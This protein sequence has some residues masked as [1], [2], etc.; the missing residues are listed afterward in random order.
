MSGFAEGSSHDFGKVPSPYAGRK[1]K[2]SEHLAISSLWFATNFLWGALL[3]LLIPNQIRA[4]VPQYRAEILGLMIGT[5][6]VIAI[7]VPLI[8][9][10]LSD[11]C[12]SRFGRRRPFIFSGILINIAGLGLMAAAYASTKPVPLGAAAS[13]FD[14][15]SQSPGIII[16][17]LAFL[18]VQLGNNIATAPYSGIIPDLIEPAQR[19]A[20]SGYMALMSQAGTLLGALVCG[21]LLG[22]ASDTIKYALIS[23]VLLFGMLITVWKVKENPL[24]ET[25]SKI[26]WGPYIKSLWISPK[27]H[28]NFAWVWITRALVMLGFYS[29]QPFINYYLID[30]IGVSPKE[31]DNV[32]PILLAVILFTSSISGILGGNISDRIGRKKVVYYANATIAIT[33]IGFIFCNTVP[34]VLL[35]GV[36]F[37]LGYGAYVSVDWALGTEV[38]PSK[39]NAAKEMAVWHIA[40]TLPQS[41]GAPIAGYALAAY[42]VTKEVVPGLDD[43][44]LH[45]QDAGYATIFII[46][47]VC[48]AFGA[49][50]LRNV[51][52]VR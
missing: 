25:Q 3:I 7:V 17:F 19:G 24:T 26:Q 34:I 11:R 42:G 51:R 8:V 30:Q 6:A 48:F 32:A 15:I 31:V 36:L 14:A 39:D 47:A 4:M 27:E 41:I 44:V 21:P 18:V 9:G 5:A 13:S 1:I 45:Y 22:S 35:V 50:L 2:T 33:S 37:G 52:G 29:I 12:T 43:P 46:A 23:G 38:L 49:I 20:A 28:P 10:A 40:M 16:Y